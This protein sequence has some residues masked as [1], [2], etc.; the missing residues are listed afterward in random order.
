MK[1]TY[2]ASSRQIYV[3]GRNCKLI[4][5]NFSQQNFTLAFNNIKIDLKI[6]YMAICIY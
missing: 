6:H 1:T 2:S 5:L 4:N 3:V